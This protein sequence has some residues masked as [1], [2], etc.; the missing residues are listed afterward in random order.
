[1]AQILREIKYNGW[2][3]VELGHANDT[4][5]TRSLEENMRRSRDYAERTFEGKA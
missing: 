4:K 5:I 3:S 1:M 2:L